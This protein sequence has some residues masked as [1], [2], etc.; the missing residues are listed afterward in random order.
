MAAFNSQP[1]IFHLWLQCRAF[2]IGNLFVQSV[3]Y[4]SSIL[5]AK[6]G[7]SSEAG[8]F[9]LPVTRYNEKVCSTTS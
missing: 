4:L 5:N 7:M 2:G 1:V 6:L 8:F 3:N 9:I